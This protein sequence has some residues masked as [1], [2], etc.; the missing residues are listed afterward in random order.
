[1]IFQCMSFHLPPLKILPD[2]FSPFT[3][4][5]R[6]EHAGIASPPLFT[7]LTTALES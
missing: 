6:L 7:L 2:V 3:G 1:M 5:L 4:E